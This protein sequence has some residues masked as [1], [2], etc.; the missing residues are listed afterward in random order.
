MYHAVVIF[1]LIVDFI[2]IRSLLLVLEML[3]VGI[4]LNTTYE[5]ERP[6]EDEFED[7]TQIYLLGLSPLKKTYICS[8]VRTNCSSNAFLFLKA[9]F[10]IV[11]VLYFILFQKSD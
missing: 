5:R 6:R 4:I 3:L 2:I 11:S 8:S 7:W 10:V 1:G 9:H